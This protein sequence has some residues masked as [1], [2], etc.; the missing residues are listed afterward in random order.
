MRPAYSNKRAEEKCSV[1]TLLLPGKRQP[2]EWNV[3]MFFPGRWL[4]YELTCHIPAFFCPVEQTG[5]ESYMPAAS[6]PSTEK[7]EQSVS[8]KKG[9]SIVF[10][11]D[12]NCFVIILLPSDCGR[13]YRA[14]TRRQNADSQNHFGKEF[15]RPDNFSTPTGT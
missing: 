8:A 5:N 6:G 1:F 3:P 10:P 15:G 13:Q 14:D 11:P 12:T 7:A 9:F 4:P 2:A